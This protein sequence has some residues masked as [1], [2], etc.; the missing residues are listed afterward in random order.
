MKI[1]PSR[2][3][4]P[5]R[6]GVAN[7]CGRL[8]PELIFI[9][10]HLCSGRR[11]ID[12][13]SNIGI[14]SYHLSKYFEIVESFEP[15]GSC[16]R[17]LQSSVRGKKNININIHNVA[18]S[19]DAALKKIHIPRLEGGPLNYGYSSIKNSFD[20]EELLKIPSQC[21]DE[22]EFDSVDFIKIDVEGHELEVLKGAITTIERHHPFCLI[23]IESRHGDSSQF[24]KVFEF[25]RSR[26]YEASF[27]YQGL[28]MSMENFN[29][30]VHQNVDTLES[31]ASYINNFLFEWQA[32]CV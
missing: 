11:A 15:I 7:L 28:R 32:P 9:S 3:D 21:L 14:Y 25:M 13:G 5:L 22:Y 12:V 29:P 19:S 8:D 10:Q 6:Y 24:D 1:I 26:G 27:L 2:Y 31:G 23:E 30:I 16:S 17:M 4:L 18:L 20:N